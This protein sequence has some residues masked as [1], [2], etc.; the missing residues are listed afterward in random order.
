MKQKISIIIPLHNEEE[1]LP[2]IERDIQ[3]MLSSSGLDGEI[4][5]VDDNSNDST[6]KMCDNL[7]RKQNVRVFHRKGNPGMGNALKDGTRKAQ[8]DI[9][10]WVMGDLSD[11]LDIIPKFTERIGNGCDMVIG[12]RYMKGGFAQIPYLK[13]LASNGFTS[14]S[15]VFLGVRVHDITNAFRAF[16]KEV[17]DSA[18]PESGDF[19][20]SPEFALKAHIKGYKLCEVSAVH[21]DRVKGVTKFNFF[22][23]GRR[24][25][26]IF[27]KA[28]VLKYFKK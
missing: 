17:F 9:I 24:Y 14:M 28:F 2:Q 26:S 5:L 10:V 19:A 22:K 25:F 27:L 20:I 16:R 13:R 11:D 18:K 23:M 4:I 8:N 15:R 7:S 12:S 3:K 6:P 21:T 1:N